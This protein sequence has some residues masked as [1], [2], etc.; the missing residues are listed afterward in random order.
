MSP[1]GSLLSASMATHHAASS[2]S[3][4]GLG[5]PLP[6]TTESSGAVNHAGTDVA[7][8]W[9]QQLLLPSNP[10]LLDARP[11]PYQM[12]RHLPKSMEDSPIA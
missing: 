2:T 10:L 9:S 3:G 11:P 7:P 6:P 12:S 4:D 8:P 1:I 5:K